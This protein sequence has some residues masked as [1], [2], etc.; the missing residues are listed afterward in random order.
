VPTTHGPFTDFKQLIAD[1][2]KRAPYVKPAFIACLE[3]QIFE[4]VDNHGSHHAEEIF[5]RLAKQCGLVIEY[6][7]Y[8]GRPLYTYQLVEQHEEALA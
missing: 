7:F 4:H 8:H 6:T 1:A 3:E 2:T 5:D